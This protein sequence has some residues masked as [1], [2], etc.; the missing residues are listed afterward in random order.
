[1]HDEVLV[2]RN[3]TRMSIV[4]AELL[5]VANRELAGEK[6]AGLGEWLNSPTQSKA[7]NMRY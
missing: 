5:A 6:A 1:M 3:T 7:A 4:E 2:T